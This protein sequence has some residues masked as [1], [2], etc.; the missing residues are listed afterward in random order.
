M[1]RAAKFYRMPSARMNSQPTMGKLSLVSGAHSLRGAACTAGNHTV[2]GLRFSPMGRDVSALL[3]QTQA[4]HIQ[5]EESDADIGKWRR[6]LEEAEYRS[7]E[8]QIK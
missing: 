1:Q 5:H 8:V 7:G 4:G 6:F 3:Q 2:R